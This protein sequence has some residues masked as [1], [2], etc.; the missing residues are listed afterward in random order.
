MATYKD[1]AGHDV[2][3][4]GLIWFDKLEYVCLDCRSFGSGPID[5][6]LGLVEWTEDDY[7]DN[8]DWIE[9]R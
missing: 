7:Y 6:L 2:K 3:R 5:E 4:S 9:S 1:H 8:I